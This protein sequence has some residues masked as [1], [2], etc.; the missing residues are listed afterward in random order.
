MSNSRRSALLPALRCAYKIDNPKVSRKKKPASQA[1]NFTSTFVV[2]APK[3]F[4]VTPAPNAAPKPSLLGRC[5]KMTSTMSKATTTQSAR[6]T[7]IKIG[8]GAGNMTRGE[9]EANVER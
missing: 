8:I 4:S 9:A 6:R 7:L 3:M 2:C 5:I 1:V